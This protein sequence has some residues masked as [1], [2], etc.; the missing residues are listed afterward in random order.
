MPNGKPRY[1]RCYDNGGETADRYTVV[2]TRT[3][4]GNCFYV[5]MGSTPFHP[6]GICLH[7]ESPS[8]IDRPAYSHL[9]KKIDFSELPD[10]CKKVILSDYT[11]IWKL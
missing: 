3:N 5:A 1:I 11:E 10:D 7:G 9:G 4:T 2:Y 8:T 6:Q